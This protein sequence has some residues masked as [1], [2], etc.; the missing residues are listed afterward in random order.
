MCC[1]FVFCT[2]FFVILRPLDG[3]IRKSVALFIKILKVAHSIASRSDVTPQIALSSP[4]N[5]PNPPPKKK[6]RQL[7]K[8]QWISFHINM[9]WRAK[10]FTETKKFW[11]KFSCS[12]FLGLCY[13]LR[14]LYFSIPPGKKLQC[15]KDSF[16]LTC[17]NGNN[18]KQVFETQ[19]FL[20]NWRRLIAK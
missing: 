11:V 15:F 19:P 7:L 13:A 4:R 3:Y 1:L 20:F 18:Y 5:F 6:K 16:F 10:D 12:A 17:K 14:Q 2:R 9:L 8:A